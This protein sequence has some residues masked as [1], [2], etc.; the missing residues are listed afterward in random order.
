MNRIL[1]A[2]LGVILYAAPLPVAA[3][4]ITS[5]DE[6]GFQ[7]AAWSDFTLINLDTLTPPL[8][9][10]DLGGFGLTSI[11]YDGPVV[12]GQAF[13]I[14]K[15]G[16]DRL[17]LNGLGFGGHLAFNLDGP[18]NG[19]GFLSNTIDYGRVIA[20]SGA[21]LTGS[22]I[23][24]ATAASGGFGGLISSVETIG[25]FQIT[26]DFNSDLRCGV[27]DIQFGVLAESSDGVPA[28]ASLALLIIGLLGFGVRRQVA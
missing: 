11:G 1:T 12:G 25:S 21:N 4:V 2:L 13:Q 6:V 8:S 5:T 14:T 16:R 9:A 28:P 3:T 17:L 22:L 18:V 23:G 27:Y 7:S 15:P 19:V 26:C 10:D 20:Y 24:Q